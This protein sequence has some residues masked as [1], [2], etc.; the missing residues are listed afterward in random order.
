MFMKKNDVKLSSEFKIQANKAILSILLFVFTYLVLLVLTVGLTV[1]C[2]YAGLMLI[3]ALPKFF[4]FIIGI[5]IASFG[6]F[7]LVFLL[8]FIFASHKIDRSYLYEIKKMDEPELFNM[9]KEIV[10]E[11]GTSFPKKVYLSNEVN[12]SVFYNSSF[13]S[14]FFPVRKNLQIGLGLVNSVTKEEIKAILSHEF[15]HFSQKSMKVGSYVYNVN[16]V[17]YNMIFENSSYE[18]LIHSWANITGFFS[19]FVSLTISFIEVVQWILRK[20]YDIVNLSYLGLSREMEFHADEI[21]VNITGTAPLR[22]SLLRTTFADY[23]FNQVLNFYNG[24]IADNLKSENIYKEHLFVMQFE[25]NSNK[26]TI[27]NG[28]PELTIDELKQI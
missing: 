17:I 1:V 26:I 12:A 18:K 28:L 13:F 14:M 25:A 2:I 5:G 22:S 16:Q 15:G 3:I 24:K 20:L 23:S 27:V 21:A 9:I 4:T 6:F 7:I 10:K 19:I 8:K 11:I